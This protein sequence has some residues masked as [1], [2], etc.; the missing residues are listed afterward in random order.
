MA[1][2]STRSLDTGTKMVIGLAS[3]AL[4][5]AILGSEPSDD[6]WDGDEPGDVEAIGPTGTTWGSSSDGFSTVPGAPDDPW[7]E[8][9]APSGDRG[10][11]TTVDDPWTR[12][13]ASFDSGDDDA[14]VPVDDPWTR[15]AT[16]ASSDAGSAPSLPA[17]DPWTRGRTPS[18]GG[19]SVSLPA[20][21]PWTRGSTPSGDDGPSPCVGTMEFPTGTGTVRLPT[22][23]PES[24][25]ASPD[26]VIARGQSGGPVLLVQKALN[27]CNG[28]SVSLT[29]TNDQAT[30][31]AL[32]DVQ[33]R[34]G[35][36]PDGVYGPST[37]RVMGWPTQSG[38]GATR[39]LTHQDID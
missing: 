17:D 29:G 33:A 31:K 39:C 11:G 2:Q 23:R 22:D 34:Q 35:L 5:F 36:T 8:G 27:A 7:S 24:A 20:D 38:D 6:A 1:K 4:L 13:G 15:G 12:G 9:G 28:K 16:S 18:D 14:D 32:S 10:S 3:L 21:D 26:C 37:R 19:S 25:F 30:A